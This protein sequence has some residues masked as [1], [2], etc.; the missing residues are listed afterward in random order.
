M[1]RLTPP[2]HHPAALGAVDQFDFV[3]KVFF[4]Q[5]G[6]FA[7]HKENYDPRRRFSRQTG[8]QKT[9]ENQQ[10]LGPFQNGYFSHSDSGI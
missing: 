3:P 8:T 6:S 7:N 2:K 5:H 1:T 9:A 10:T 4:S